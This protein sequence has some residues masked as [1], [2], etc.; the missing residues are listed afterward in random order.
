M[1]S[2]EYREHLYTLINKV[3]GREELV[4]LWKRA[5]SKHW[6][7]KTAKS[8]LLTTHF[9]LLTKQELTLKQQHYLVSL[10]NQE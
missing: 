10:A 2:D 7:S 5:T 9:L 6:F 1:T 4:K 3:V 8:F